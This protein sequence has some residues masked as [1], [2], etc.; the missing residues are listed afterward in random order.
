MHEIHGKKYF[1]GVYIIEVCLRRYKLKVIAGTDAI[2]TSL[3]RVVVDMRKDIEHLDSGKY[4]VSLNSK[5]NS[6]VIKLKKQDGK[7]N[8]ESTL[9]VGGLFKKDVVY[10]S[11]DNDS[12]DI[13]VIEKPRYVSEKT[14]LKRVQNFLSELINK[15]EKTPTKSESESSGKNGFVYKKSLDYFGKQKVTK[16]IE[17]N[18]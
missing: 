8:D 7:P 18:I 4:T 6:G 9:F 13:L 14:V 3:S 10:A 15:K 1:Q 11:I 17:G 12:G 16:E 5:K 2:R